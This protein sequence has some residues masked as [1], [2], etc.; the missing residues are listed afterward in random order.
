MEI[1]S[2][3][4]ATLRCGSIYAC[5]WGLGDLLET[6]SLLNTG[7]ISPRGMSWLPDDW[8]YGLPLCGL[9]LQSR[10]PLGIGPNWRDWGE[11]CWGGLVFAS[12]AA[13]LFVPGEKDFLQSDCHAI[14]SHFIHP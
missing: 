7:S 11:G 3:K 2:D 4:G 8:V 5:I 12:R 10:L 6:M 13:Y 14:K 9:G 1:P